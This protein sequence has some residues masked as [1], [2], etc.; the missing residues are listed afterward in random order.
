MPR[1]TDDI[2]N[3]T[4]RQIR[5]SLRLAV[6][7]LANCHEGL[8]RS[9]R[10]IR[11]A[12]NRPGTRGSQHAILLESRMAHLERLARMTQESTGV[13][14]EYGR[15]LQADPDD[16]N[17]VLQRMLAF[18]RSVD[19]QLRCERREARDILHAMHESP[20]TPKHRPTDGPPEHY[21]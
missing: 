2:T 18:A 11:A 5:A 12:L 3:Q 10:Q 8:N 6:E 1:F 16:P 20:A 19:D 17:D 14:N 13:L 21:Q 15:Q 4:H 9:I 7:R